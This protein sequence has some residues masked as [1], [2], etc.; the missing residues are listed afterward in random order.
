MFEANVDLINSANN[1][2]YDHL[3][4]LTRDNREEIA[5][6]QWTVSGKVK[7]ITRTAG[8]NK[9][10]MSFGYGAD[11]QR[12]T[13]TVGDPTAGGYREYYLRDAQGNIM[14]T[15]TYTS[16][17][18]GV[19]MKCTD[20]PI[21]G[22]KRIGNY[23]KPAE[24][25]WFP[26]PTNYVNY[27]EPMS[28]Y[29]LHYEL[30]DHLGNVT[31]VVTGHLANGND[32]GSPWQ[33]D[34]KTAQGYEAF[35]SLLPGRSNLVPTGV[36]SNA[37][38][39]NEDFEGAQ[40][41]ANHVNGWTSN[42][43]GVFS[44]DAGNTDR[45]K[46]S[47]AVVFDGP[48]LV[49]ATIPNEPY[50][51]TLDIDLGT[52]T[53]LAL[54]VYSVTPYAGIPGSPIWTSSGTKTFTF[55]ATSSQTRIKILKVYQPSTTYF[56]IDNVKVE[57][58]QQVFAGNY[59]FGFNGKENDNEVHGATG[60]FQDYGKRAYDTRVGR[61][62]SVDPISAQYP[63]L[64][65]YQFASNSPIQNIDVDGLEG[66]FSMVD[67]NRSSREAVEA[68]TIPGAKDRIL[69]QRAIEAKVCGAIIT[70][71]VVPASYVLWGAEAATIAGVGIL[72]QRA[73]DNY[74]SLPG[75]ESLQGAVLPIIPSPAAWGSMPM[76]LV[77]PMEAET[78]LPEMRQ[79][80]AK[81]FYNKFGEARV[82]SKLAGID[83]TKPVQTRTLSAG[84]T[85]EQWVGADGKMGKYFAPVGS[86]PATLG[87]SVE[88][89]TLQQFTLNEDVKVLQ[90]TAADLGGNSGGGVQYFS[91]ELS[92]KVTPKTGQ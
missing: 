83:F 60:T 79:A 47:D 58:P 32:A 16:T 59:R 74:A 57:G 31:A 90:S 85:V 8:S 30:N 86:D 44:M 17:G 35:G 18:H 2:G 36:L 66:L 71:A 51:V 41:V 15:Y 42:D 6:I 81:N 33:A 21:Y 52:T 55:T 40:V 27:V 69:A 9:P 62:F 12:I 1:Y 73:L 5:D 37:L 29:L 75:N 88:G 61:F 14:A 77:A 34:L 26:I 82:D 72:G 4:N 50:T 49:F 11:G 19:S 78:S 92:T 84:T 76:R 91:P 56:Y 80:L 43:V 65:P 46:V 39:V 87:I 54:A 63:M 22:S 89:R 45:L 3:G 7:S 53:G 10:E 13:K 28:E 64:T 67:Y 70:M 24:I 38:V 48:Q 68:M 25:A 20:R 23:T